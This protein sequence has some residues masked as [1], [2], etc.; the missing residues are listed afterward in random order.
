M[1]LVKTVLLLALVLPLAGCSGKSTDAPPAAAPL[2]VDE[3]HKLPPEEKYE[4]ETFERLKLG[5]PKLQNQRAWDQFTRSVILP[6][7][8]RD[9]PNQPIK[10]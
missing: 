6:S 2:T 4:I 10:R 5:N 8:K 1:K 3:W 9:L 7:R